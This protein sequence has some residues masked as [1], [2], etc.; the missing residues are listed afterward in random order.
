MELFRRRFTIL[1]LSQRLQMF[2]ENQHA[3]VDD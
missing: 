1:H 2:S 3:D